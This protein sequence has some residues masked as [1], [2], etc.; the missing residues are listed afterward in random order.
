[1][2]NTFTKKNSKS[3][4]ITLS[5]QLTLILLFFLSCSVPISYKINKKKIAL[6]GN[7][8]PL[9]IN[10]VFVNSWGPIYQGQLEYSWSGDLDR[11]RKRWKVHSK[12]I[13][14]DFF[15]VFSKEAN[16]TIKS[17]FDKEY[18]DLKSISKEQLFTLKI[19]FET[20]EQ[21]VDHSVRSSGTVSGHKVVP[22]NSYDAYVN[23]NLKYEF[24]SPDGEPIV[25][26]YTTGHGKGRGFQMGLLISGDTGYKGAFVG[27]LK[28]SYSSAIYEACM[29]LVNELRNNN[30]IALVVRK[31]QE[32]RSLPADLVVKLQ[33]CDE[34]SLIPNNMIDPVEKSD[35][36]VAITNNGKGTAFDA[37]LHIE[38]DCKDVH[39]PKKITIGDIQ[40]GESKQV[41]VN[42]EATADLLDGTVP[43]W[44]S[45][46]ES[47]GYDSKKYNLNVQAVKLVQPQ[48]AII[49]YKI[50]DG[51]SGLAN[52]NGNG[53]PENGETIEIIPFVRNNGPGQ[54]IKVSLKIESVSSRIEIKRGNADIPQI[55]PGQTVTEHLAF[56]I[57]PSFR[58]KEID[59]NLVASDVR[60]VSTTHK[61]F[62]LNTI[63]RRPVLAYNYKIIDSNGNGFLENGEEGEIE[64]VPVNKGAMAARDINLD[65]HSKDISF[66]NTHAF[67]NQINAASS[68]VPLRFAFTTP[69]VLNKDSINIHMQVNQKDFPGFEDTIN[70][71]IKSLSPALEITHQVLDQNNNG[72]IEK[73]E[74]I[75]LIVKVRNSGGLCA[76]NVVL[77]MEVNSEGIIQ[78]GIML[79]GNKTIPLGKIAAGRESEPQRFTI[80]VQRRAT[81]GDMPVNF[82][83]AQQDFP[84][85]DIV[86]SLGIEQEQPEIITVAGKKAT[87]QFLPVTHAMSNTPP[88]IA[89][90]SPKDQKRTASEVEIFTGTIVD[91]KGVANV[92]ITLNGRRLSDP[93]SV[94]G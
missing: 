71:P 31:V 47:R 80:H 55:L 64:I 63:T 38:S 27:A 67:I 76:E 93:R 60:G 77:N 65:L 28:A 17:A 66:S 21:N 58:S 42:L 25:A 72:I 15:D 57:P 86:F 39:F 52:G 85:E 62:T 46:R 94:G 24:I 69:R 20:T 12:E 91:D 68:Y 79:S 16:N 50:N 5:I 35:I 89:I 87:Q 90:A 48:V 36:N 33:Y 4:I 59:L 45:C 26:G 75:D 11:L 40:P 41:K 1:M 61:L 43:F 30:K 73:G 92:E 88:L 18:H 29:L 3:N 34:F 78:D 9:P 7:S 83:I 19:A 84:N 82:S 37:I 44:L 8:I 2:Q 56:T 22:Q 51:A 74:T 10:I 6:T 13:K 81:A 53:V 54:A 49:N 70:I 32:K 23:G 14:V